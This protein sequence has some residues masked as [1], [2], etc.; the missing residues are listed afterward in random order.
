MAVC[1]V[2][3]VQSLLYLLFPRAE[4]VPAAEEVEEV[5][6]MMGGMLN[7]EVEVV[8]VKLVIHL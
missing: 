7:T 4:G 1:A 6:I 2:L 3:Q 8:V 5:E